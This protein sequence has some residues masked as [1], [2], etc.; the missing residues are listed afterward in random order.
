MRIFVGFKREISCTDLR[1]CLLATSVT[2]FI[3]TLILLFSGI[4]ND[5]MR[6]EIPWLIPGSIAWM[7]LWSLHYLLCGIALGLVAGN[8]NCHKRMIGQG[9]VLWAFYLLATLF[10]AP[11]FFVA[12]MEITGLL[13]VA[14]AVFVGACVL[15][16]F[17]RWSILSALLM[18]CCIGWQIYS[19]LQS[20]LIILWN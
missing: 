7:I 6:L 19:F 11:V 10:W 12:G 13:L 1:I 4:G 8:C 2:W 18:L 17:A 3:S 16:S 14:I 5:C 9:M 15:F 20:L